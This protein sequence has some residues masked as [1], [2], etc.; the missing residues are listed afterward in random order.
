M[1]DDADHRSDRRVSQAIRGV[2]VLPQ[3]VIADQVNNDV[4]VQHVQRRFAQL[5]SSS[6][7]SISWSVSSPG[8]RPIIAR[9]SPDGSGPDPD[10]AL[11][12]PQRTGFLPRTGDSRVAR[13]FKAGTT[14]D[15]I[16]RPTRGRAHPALRDFVFFRAVD[17]AM[18]RWATFNLPL[19]GSMAEC[20]M[21]LCRSPAS[22]PGASRISRTQRFS[23][24]LHEGA[25]SLVGHRDQPPTEHVPARSGIRGNSAAGGLGA[26]RGSPAWRIDATPTSRCSV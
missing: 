25:A 11:E 24:T 23:E 2:R 3:R 8:Q 17:P 5:R 1:C 26:F 21:D 12:T 10:A 19:R 13:P 22:R 18:N 7:S 15:G 6:A 9:E 16:G 20:G 4:C 14:K